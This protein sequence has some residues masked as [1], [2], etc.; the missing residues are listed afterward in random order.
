MNMQHALDENGAEIEVREE[1]TG[2]FLTYDPVPSIFAE[3]WIL[4]N[5]LY[6]FSG[7]VPFPHRIEPRSSQM[8][9][10]LS[11]SCEYIEAVAAA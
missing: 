7:P 2:L 10:L 1:F 3:L 8:M 5:H 11:E 9:K 4:T 6:L